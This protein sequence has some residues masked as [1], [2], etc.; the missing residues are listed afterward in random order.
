MKLHGELLT[1]RQGVAG[2]L[3]RFVGPGATGA[4]L[5]LQ[6]SLPLCAAIV[7]P[8]YAAYAVVGWSHAQYLIC[9]ILAFDVIGGVITNATSSGKRWYHRAGQ[10]MSQHLGFVTAHLAHLFLVGW[11]Y[12]GLDLDWP[13]VSGGYLIVTS[14]AIIG[15]P[16]Y[17]R[18][19]VALIAYMGAL[20]LSIYMLTAPIGLEWFLPL[21][22][23]KL[24]VAHLPREEPYRP[25]A[26]T[27]TANQ[28]P[29]PAR[30]VGGKGD[31]NPQRR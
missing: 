21:F 2:V 14:A 25:D 1:P 22:Y 6:F 17:L 12:P 9:A 11:I 29:D 31:S 26:R 3:D 10:G 28:E 30:P 20:L 15:A 5:M 8:A 13:A 27:K 18:R 23:L 4:E 16:L 7:A 24:L 19:P